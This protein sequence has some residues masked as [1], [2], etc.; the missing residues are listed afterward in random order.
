MRKY[1]DKYLRCEALAFSHRDGAIVGKKNWS[2]TPQLFSWRL[3]VAK[4][5]EQLSTGSLGIESPGDLTILTPGTRNSIYL[6]ISNW[7]DYAKVTK[8]ERPIYNT[9]CQ[10][11]T[12]LRDSISFQSSQYSSQLTKS[13]LKTKG[14]AWPWNISTFHSKAFLQS[15]KFLQ[16]DQACP[17]PG[18][19]QSVLTFYQPGIQ[20]DK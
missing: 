20:K 3:P 15:Q 2:S 6:I 5:I 9:K 16:P 14:N 13:R 19:Q 1:W 17:Q 8:T 10:L 7:P 4:D 11:T 18:Q 12:L